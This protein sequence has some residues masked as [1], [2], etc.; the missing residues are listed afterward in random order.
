MRGALFSGTLKYRRG[1]CHE[2]DCG[3]HAKHAAVVG[4]R[5]VAYGNGRIPRKAGFARKDRR[6]LL[7]LPGRAGEY[8]ADGGQ[9][10]SG[11]HV[12]KPAEADRVRAQGDAALQIRTAV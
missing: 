12:G 11:V 5:A 6:Y 2:R 8:S 7:T 9:P 1:K 3:Q 10:S 4:G